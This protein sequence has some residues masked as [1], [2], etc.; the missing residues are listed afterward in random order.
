VVPFVL[1]GWTAQAG[2]VPYAGRLMRIGAWAEAST[3]TTEQ[4]RIYWVP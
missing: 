2:E 1:G 3:T 4:N